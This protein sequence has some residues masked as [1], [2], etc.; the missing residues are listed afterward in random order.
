MFSVQNV[1][2]IGVCSKW[3]LE[4]NVYSAVIGWSSLEM[5]VCVCVCVQAHAHALSDVQLETPWSIAHQALLS[6]GFY[7]Q[8]YWRGLPLPPLG[9]SIQP[10]DQSHVSC[11]GRQVLYH[12]ATWKA[13]RCQCIQLI[14]G[15]VEFTYFNFYGENIFM[16]FM[17][18]SCRVP[19]RSN[20]NNKWRFERQ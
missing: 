18:Y 5:C 1:V 3:A 17:S 7:L 13:H 6:M 15:A 8:E 19:V 2:D 14:K 11:I 12:W 4:K 9:A 20:K 16:Y 10:R